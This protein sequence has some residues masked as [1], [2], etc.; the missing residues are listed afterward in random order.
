ME[1]GMRELMRHQ[2]C[3]PAFILNLFRADGTELFVE[4]RARSDEGH[5]PWRE[6]S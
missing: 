6:Q 3:L 2:S 4:D 5:I 1:H